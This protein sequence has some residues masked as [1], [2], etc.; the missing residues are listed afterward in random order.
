MKIIHGLPTFFFF[1]CVAFSQEKPLPPLTVVPSVDL[2]KYSGTWF[3]IARLPNSY[4]KSCTGDVTATY[5]IDGDELIVVN[6]CRKEN[7]EMTEAKGRAR[8]AD[9]EG[10]NSKLEVRFA[11]AFLSFLRFVW[12]DY[13]IIDLADDYSFAVIGGPEREYLWILARTK[14]LPE[15]T[16]QE[17]LE[18]I[19]IQGYDIQKLIRTKQTL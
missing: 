3:E 19:K 9:K 17:I 14:T 8:R 16:M 15:P 6:R 11:P 5:T 13:W 10:P 12:G 7:G 1:I 4:Q 2:Q 18:R